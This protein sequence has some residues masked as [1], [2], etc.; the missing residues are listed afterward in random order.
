[1]T[2]LALALYGHE[3]ARIQG[4]ASVAR[5][6]LWRIP[7]RQAVWRRRARGGSRRQADAYRAI[8]AAQDWGTTHNTEMMAESRLRWR[9]A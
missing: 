5:S 9:V 7:E 2:R 8:R 6:G 3:E 1:M 4:A